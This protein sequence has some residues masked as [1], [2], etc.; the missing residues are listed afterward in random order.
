[1]KHVVEQ[2]T[3]RLAAASPAATE[4]ATPLDY[5]LTIEFLEGLKSNVRALSNWHIQDEAL[6][7]KYSEEELYDDAFRK[8]DLR[9]VLTGLASAGWKVRSKDS[10]DYFLDRNGDWPIMIRVTDR[11]KIWVR[12]DREETLLEIPGHKVIATALKKSGYKYREE[13]SVGDIQLLKIVVES[14]G[15]TTALLTS[16]VKKALGADFTA[17]RSDYVS[18]PWSKSNTTRL[19]LLRPSNTTYLVDA[20][21]I[22]YTIYQ[23]SET[24]IGISADWSVDS[25]RSKK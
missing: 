4:T 5:E 20:G 16:L 21:D 3:A 22:R 25:W 9:G 19:R 6:V 13:R 15:A 2:A 10:L 7:R 1:M 23:Y 14:A 17:N 11:L 18:N 8:R 24:E 12:G